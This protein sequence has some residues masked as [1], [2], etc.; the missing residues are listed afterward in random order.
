[1]ATSDSPSLEA[2][3]EWLK[4]RS[5]P[6]AFNF[7]ILLIRDGVE[8]SKYPLIGAVGCPR[9]AP[10]AGYGIHPDHWGAGFATEAVLAFIDLYWRLIPSSTQGVSE[11]E[12]IG[13]HSNDTKQSK[14]YLRGAHD[15]IEALADSGN[16]ASH[17]VLDKCG[18]HLLRKDKRGSDFPGE[19][20]FIFRYRLDRPRSMQ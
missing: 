10:E 18:F 6:S 11:G 2:D 9:G 1:M 19:G 14:P 16:I 17:R 3:R 13:E 12:L 7:A 8:P 20:D 15:H 5:W 4:T